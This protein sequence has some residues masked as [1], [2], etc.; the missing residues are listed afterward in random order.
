[1]A[2]TEWWLPGTESLISGARSGPP[3]GG[4]LSS[5]RTARA[6]ETLTSTWWGLVGA[7]KVG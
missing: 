1:M 2:V 3:K 5:G 4:S 6:R 7:G